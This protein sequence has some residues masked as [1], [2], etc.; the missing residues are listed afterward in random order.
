MAMQAKTVPEL[1]EIL[2][3]PHT[4]VCLWRGRLMIANINHPPCVLT[5]DGLVEL[6][7]LEPRHG[8]SFV[9]EEG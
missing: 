6:G 3:D 5:P 8:M 1:C 9:T 4:N 2:A 7:F